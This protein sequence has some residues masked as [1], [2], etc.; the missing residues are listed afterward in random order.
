MNFRKDDTPTRERL[1]PLEP[2][3][4][5]VIVKDLQEEIEDL[6]PTSA[7]LAVKRKLP[8]SIPTKGEFFEIPIL[9]EKTVFNDI[10]S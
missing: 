3:Q 9:K 6:S 7:R 10:D 4:T 2:G 5:T 8:Y 1:A